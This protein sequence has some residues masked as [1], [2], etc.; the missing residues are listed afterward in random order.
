LINPSS[1]DDLGGIQVLG[2]GLADLPCIEEE[3][4]DESGEEAV[5]AML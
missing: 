1:G 4:V 2:L 5:P 3:V